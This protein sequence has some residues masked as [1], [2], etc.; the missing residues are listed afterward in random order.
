[1]RDL[2]PESAADRTLREWFDEQ[3]KQNLARL[4]EGAKAITQL[5]TALYGV[6]F[7]V[8]ALSGHPQP[9]Y[10]GRPAV[11]WSGSLALVAFFA[12]LVAALVTQFPFRAGYQENNV[13]AMEHAYRSIRDRKARSLAVALCAFLLGVLCLGGLISAILWKL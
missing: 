12:A 7:A 6:L 13:S 5:V 1:M 11:Q 3:E 2:G 8:L 10:L 4:E 9:A